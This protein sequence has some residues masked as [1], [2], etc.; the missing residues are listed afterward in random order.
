[1]I[2]V[3]RGRVNFTFLDAVPNG[4]RH[5]LGTESGASW[6]HI[7]NVTSRINTE[8]NCDWKT[9][10]SA[11]FCHVVKRVQIHS[12]KWNTEREAVQNTTLN[13]STH[14]CFSPLVD[15][16]NYVVVVCA[17]L[18][19]REM[20]QSPGHITLVPQCNTEW[21]STCL[22]RY[23]WDYQQGVSKVLAHPYVRLN[24]ESWRFLRAI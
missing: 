4:W 7:N 15:L 19:W 22:T 23:T 24:L 5:F 17:P 12:T 14:K 2:H 11:S 16:C 1:M 13:S 21:N 8:S 3:F 6:N 10:A 18:G 20:L 9:E